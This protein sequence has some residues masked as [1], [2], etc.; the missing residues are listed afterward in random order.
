MIKTLDDPLYY[1]ANFHQVVDW[2]AGRYADLLADDERAFIT[3]FPT[4]PQPSQALLVRMVMRKGSLFR[5]S[6]LT[7]PEIGDVRQAISP[8]LELGWVVADPIISLDDLFGLLKKAEI[9]CAFGLGADRA[10]LKKTSQLEALRADFSDPRPC[11]AWWDGMDDTVYE[12]RI[13]PLCDRLRLMYFGNLHQDWSTFVLSD[14]GIHRYEKVAFSVASRGFGLRQDLDD[15]LHLYQCRQR[16][17]DGIPIE[18]VLAEMP[19]AVHANPWLEARHAK[20][21]FEIAAHYEQ[22]GAWSAAFHHYRQSSYP[23]ARVRAIRV[24]DKS[25]QIATAFD[26]AEAALA[27]PES[28]A[29]CQQLMRLIP[30]LR[31]KLGL[32][33]LI[34][35]PELP[36]NATRL[37]LP[38]PCTPF[39]VEQLVRDALHQ[40][41]APVF[42]VENCLI[43]SL[44]GLLCW[45]AVFAAVP[46]AFFHPFQRGPADLHSADFVRRRQL[47]FSECLAQLASDQYQ[48]TI[49][50]NYRDKAGMQSPFV[51]WE[52]LTAEILELALNC[53][54][55]QHLKKWFERM[56]ADTDANR[57]GYPDLIQFWP[58]EKRYRM[59]EVKGP[60]DRLQDNQR[61][62]LAYC[63]EHDMPVQVCYVEWHED[64]R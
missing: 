13:M 56:L 62:W 55:A 36:V 64:A 58:D 10:L 43:N 20:L 1:L 7:Y 61:R 31:R 19:V 8:L 26:M 28:D 3:C 53:L 37:K 14:L 52:S 18:N 9:A 42:Y 63:A 41:P 50:R 11:S 23:G 54:P 30:R 17:N 4:L 5:T 32:P 49:R 48:L 46:G 51:S 24:L 2:I 25:S 29:E 16:L 27:M 45:N 47:E 40:L 21:W 6:K 33:K 34:A 15:Y 12:L 35:C 38:R 39:Q 60:G 59:I 22:C 44:F 57:A